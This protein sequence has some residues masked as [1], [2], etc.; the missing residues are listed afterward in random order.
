MAAGQTILRVSALAAGL[1]ASAS[2]AY[3][4]P[5]QPVA[6]GREI[7]ERACAGCHAID[8]G[9]G[10]VIQGTDVPSFRAIAGRSDW[11]QERLKTF[12]MTPHRPMPSISLGLS[13]VNALVA[14]IRSLK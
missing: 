5:R 13:E 9:H 8:G 4:Q 14:Y 11:T 1:C 10:S 3:A 2:L 7:A 12:I 6:R